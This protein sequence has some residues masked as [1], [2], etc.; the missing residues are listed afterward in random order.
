MTKGFFGSR[1]RNSNSW[2]GGRGGRG[3]Q[4]AEGAEGADRGD[5]GVKE[6]QC[7]DRK[8]LLSLVTARTAGP[9]PNATAIE[10]VKCVIEQM[11]MVAP[12]LTPAEG[13]RLSGVL[14][15]W[16]RGYR[17]VTRELRVGEPPSG[18]AVSGHWTS[19]LNLLSSLTNLETLRVTHY[20][21]VFG[22]TK[23]LGYRLTQRLVCL[24]LSH[25]KMWCTDAGRLMGALI[26]K[27]LPALE[28][29]LLIDC[30][31]GD[32]AIEHLAVAVLS[33]GCRNLVELELGDNTFRESILSLATALNSTCVSSA[34]EK[35]VG[36][37]R[38]PT[39]KL[40]LLGLGGNVLQ[41][42]GAKLLVLGLSHCNGRDSAGMGKESNLRYLTELNVVECG[43]ELEG[44]EALC[45]GLRQGPLSRLTALRL[46][47]NRLGDAGVALLA[48]AVT[49]GAL[50]GLRDLDLGANYLS[51]NGMRAL[52]DVVKTGMALQ[53]LRRLNLSFNFLT[54]E[55][56]WA[57][58][59]CCEFG[60][61]GRENARDDDGGMAN[62]GGWAFLQQCDMYMN[63]IT[64]KER[65]ELQLAL[66]E[67]APGLDCF[68]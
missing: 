21:S 40:R 38:V 41:K 60:E 15:S 19:L 61:G 31:L 36:D 39:T 28:R 42:E 50:S 54:P 30:G 46:N 47:A 27:Y 12:F 16:T 58:L 65:A 14:R 68:M 63:E 53:Q 32:R 18:M 5:G 13:L 64:A 55:T 7:D 9:T 1:G 24:E 34:D 3:G 33:G 62:Q 35:G 56:V 52:L 10:K 8:V 26:Q 25:S 57:L 49:E 37:E 66:K 51:D 22:V 11:H 6:I 20:R 45:P 43:L 48:S 44:L 23:C 17:E 29:L 59:Q 4:G 67:R 2:R